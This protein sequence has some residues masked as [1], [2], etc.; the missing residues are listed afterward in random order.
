MP[1]TYGNYLVKVIWLSWSCFQWWCSWPSSSIC[2]RLGQTSL[3][4]KMMKMKLLTLKSPALN[5]LKLISI[6]VVQQPWEIFL[7]NGHF[8]IWKIAWKSGSFFSVFSCIILFQ[9][10]ILEHGR[11]TTFAVT[12]LCCQPPLR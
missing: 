10:K 8:Q 11:A 9:R 3:V 5:M 1:H 7:E 2:S 4:K 12:T 6:Y